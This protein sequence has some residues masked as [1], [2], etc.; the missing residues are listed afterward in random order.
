MTRAR[1]FTYIAL[2]TLL[3][4]TAA[5][6]AQINSPLVVGTTVSCS[7]AEFVVDS[8]GDSPAYELT[9][10]LGD[11][12]LLVEEG[13]SE[14]P[15][16]LVHDYLAAGEYVWS[17][18]VT[19]GAASEQTGGVVSIEGPSVNLTS[20][21]FPPLLNAES[22][23][24]VTFLAEVEGGETPYSFAWDLNGDGVLDEP[25]DPDTPGAASYVYSEP[26]KVVVRVQVTDACG[27]SASATLPVL[28][29]DPEEDEDGEGSC[30]PAAQKIAD[31]INVLFPDQAETL[32]T[33]EEIY[34]IF[35]GG[36]TGSQLGFGILNHAIK[37]AESIEGLTWEEIRDW[38]LEGTGWGMLAQ[39]D[40]YADVVDGIGIG[41]LLELVKS[42][43]YEYAD[44]RAALRYAVRFDT[45][46]ED[47]LARLDTG[48]SPGEIGQLYRTAQELGVD[49]STLDAYL[50]EGVSLSDVRHAAKSA[51]QLRVD[52]ET[53]LDAY[54][55]GNGWGD[56][57]QAYKLANENM[58]ADEILAMG[59]KEYR[60]QAREQDRTP[61]QDE[62]DQRTAAQ[63][64][65][66]FGI[67]E[68]AV[69]AL[70][71]GT[72]NSDW[73]CVRKYYQKNK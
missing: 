28:L 56:I 44:I 59:I 17:V 52:W 4:P 60:K 21:P 2:A 63:I 37:L 15:H 6:G 18:S 54:N 66:K 69:W 73:G 64:A 48:A 39:L 38:H 1:L 29:N 55:A 22:D 67:G 16:V 14:F 31:G 46:F 40:R 25:G 12:V 10:N 42:G 9:W 8:P 50:A 24:L 58:S 62:K 11:D 30:H 13:I 53:L 20:E 65:S 26:G 57:K 3:V 34:D 32:Y 49:L 19:D 47:V 27:L 70:Y 61:R 43:D 5:A 23:G 33:C 36:L 7:S 51:D 72:C 71:K 35:V 45:D 41:D 68:D